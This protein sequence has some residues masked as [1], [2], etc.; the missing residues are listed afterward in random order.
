M[1]L[2]LGVCVFIL[3]SLNVFCFRIHSI[4]F[5]TCLPGCRSFVLLAAGVDGP[6]RARSSSRSAKAAGWSRGGPVWGELS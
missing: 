1:H 4:S 5:R 3:S 2:P 6:E